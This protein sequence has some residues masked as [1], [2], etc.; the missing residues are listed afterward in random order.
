MLKLFLITNSFKKEYTICGV[1]YIKIIVKFI[2]MLLIISQF[3]I[4]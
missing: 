3:K 1:S 2:Q 4:W